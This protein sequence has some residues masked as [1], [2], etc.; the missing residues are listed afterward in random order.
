LPPSF[1]RTFF[2][3]ARDRTTRSLGR[4]IFLPPFTALPCFETSFLDVDPAYSV[5][6]ALRSLGLVR[7]GLRPHATLFRP[8]LCEE[9]FHPRFEAEKAFGLI[10]P[11]LGSSASVRRIVKFIPGSNLF[12]FL[13]QEWRSIRFVSLP[14][15][16]S[17]F[18]VVHR[19]AV[20][21]SHWA[22]LILLSM[23]LRGSVPG[24]RSPYR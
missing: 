4:G 3:S 5:D 1:L 9:C 16:C 22:L 19:T 6:F 2:R 14:S 23:L 8:P 15:A 13:N 21:D 12:F 11:N 7:P 18:L 20:V 17:F 10:S 24:R